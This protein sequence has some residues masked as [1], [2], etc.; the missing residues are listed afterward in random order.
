M[1]NPGVDQTVQE[2]LTVLSWTVW[3]AFAVDLT[4]RLYLGRVVAVVLM[5]VGIGLVG[6]ATASVAS[7]MLA[8]IE[9][10]RHHDRT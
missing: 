8:R 6:T 3:A 7:W 1:I 10:Q 5:V 4:V 9:T 2:T